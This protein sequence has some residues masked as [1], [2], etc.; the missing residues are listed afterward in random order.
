M[1]PFPSPLPQAPPFC[2]HCGLPIC[3]QTSRSWAGLYPY[4]CY[5]LPGSG[6]ISF[7]LSKPHFLLFVFKSFF[8]TNHIP[9]PLDLSAH[10]IPAEEIGLDISRVHGS[11]SLSVNWTRG[12]CL[13]EGN[14]LKPNRFYP[15]VI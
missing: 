7:C 6:C 11:L 15:P 13:A 14:P 3:L 12:L 1:S 4:S 8:S 10:P 9:F 2:I 5:L